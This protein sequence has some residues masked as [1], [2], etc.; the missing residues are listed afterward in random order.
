MVV[1]NSPDGLFGDFSDA[2]Y[3]VQSVSLAQNPLAV[4][5][6]TAALFNDGQFHI[7]GINA[8]ESTTGTH[9]L[10]TVSPNATPGLAM[11]PNATLVR[12][13]SVAGVK[14]TDN[15]GDSGNMLY[16]L[17]VVSPNTIFAAFKGRITAVT[18]SFP[19]W[20]YTVQ[21][22]TSYNST[23]TGAARWV[24][25]GVNIVNVL[26]RTEF[27]GTPP[28][29]YGTGNL[30]TSSSGQVNSTACVVQSIGI[31]AVPDV[32]ATLDENNVIKFSF[33]EMNSSQ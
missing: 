6:D 15:P 9:S 21:R 1:N 24:T 14:R 22:V 29:T 25:D 11:P 30:I 18:S 4:S 28:Y 2:R 23:L 16:F 19:A 10:F 17:E 27:S 5:T 3:W 33:S 26:N 7:V 8:A 32:T 20:S 12:V 13:S 31:G